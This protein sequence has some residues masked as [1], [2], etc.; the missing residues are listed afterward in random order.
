MNCER[1]AE[2][3]I[4]HL[5]GALSGPE[6]A[7]LDGHLA[8]CAACRAAAAEAAEA[9]NLLGELQAEPAD[10]ERVRAR[11]FA[12]LEA[13]QSETERQRLRGGRFGAWLETWWPQ[14]PAAQLAMALAALVAGV[15]LG[16]RAPGSASG[17]QIE[18]LRGE[19]AAMNRIVALSLLEHPSASERLR[20]V[21]FSRESA[22]D[23]E[24]VAALLGRV[25][26]DPSVNVRIAAVETLA[27]MIERPDVREGLI[28]ALARQT[29]PAV[30]VAV[31]D[32]LARSGGAGSTSAIHELLQREPLIEPVREHLRALTGGKT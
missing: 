16:Q 25:N 21:G 20:A 19:V 27:T 17:A 7:I 22:L 4:D 12:M 23:A 3:L 31:A 32:L 11:F 29:S 24:V 10:T 30:Q 5:R 1:A 26:L 6:R 18:L 14:R 13:H 28:E 15:L 2:H 9:W 8:A